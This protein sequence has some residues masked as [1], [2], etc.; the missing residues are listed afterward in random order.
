MLTEK[1]V[2]DYE[3]AGKIAQEAVIYSKSIIKP[4]VPLLE[5]AEKIEDKIKE[6][7]G[8]LAFPVNLCID[9]IAA[10][11]TPKL[12]DKTKAE[13]L[14]KVDI[15]VHVSGCI[16]DTAFSLDL[17]QDKRYSKLVEASEKALE[18][19]LEKAKK[20]SQLNEI[21]KAIQE[22]ITSLGFSPIRNLSG[23]SLGEYIIHEGA[24][25]P[26]Y[27]NGNTNELKEGVYAIEPFAT[28][29]TGV[30]KDGKPSGIYRIEKSGAVR[31]SL[32]REILRFAEEKYRTL[33]F[34]QRVIEKKFGSRALLS[35]RFLEQAGILH[36]YSQLV[37]KS[38]QPVSQAEHTI[39]ITDKVE[40]IS[41]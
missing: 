34:S 20:N 7:G 5:I 15:G 6:L 11:Y 8:E 9:D 18:K 39:I 40:V 3:R 2:K 36:Q 25:I 21:G 12:N 35:L 19:A 37:E 17:T 10:H 23:H 22:A 33:P 31:D 27:N 41:R 26:N 38:N 29:G 28:T 14:L 16:A 13:G 30:V 24:T 1:Q 4:N 32:A